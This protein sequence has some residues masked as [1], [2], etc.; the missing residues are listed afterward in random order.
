MSFTTQASQLT[1]AQPIISIPFLRGDVSA[2][3]IGSIAT[4]LTPS[5]G[6][7]YRLLGGMI[8]VSAAASVL[9]EDNAAGA[10]NF[11]CRTPKIA[12]DTPFIFDLGQGY[13]SPTAGNVLKATASAAGA[14]TGT[15]Y[16]TEE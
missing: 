1:G 10:A 14:M 6:K 16:Y 9:F 2:V 11:I 5:N 3:A 4:V 7:K 8:S 13:V 15:L 12:T